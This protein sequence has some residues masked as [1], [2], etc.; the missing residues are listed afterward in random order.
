MG[1][2]PHSSAA[3]RNDTR[4]PCLRKLY[5]FNWSQ[6]GHWRRRNQWYL[7]RSHQ[8]LQPQQGTRHP[9]ASRCERGTFLLK[10]RLR[11]SR[12][13]LRRKWKTNK[14]KTEIR[15]TQKSVKLNWRSIPANREAIYWR[16]VSALKASSVDLDQDLRLW[17]SWRLDSSLLISLTIMKNVPTL[18]MWLLIPIHTHGWSRTQRLSHVGVTFT[19]RT[20]HSATRN[21]R[22]HTKIH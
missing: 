1:V 15:E 5:L 12:M 4:S 19:F 18:T 22:T 2:V 6:T 16:L 10:S 8:S 20:H 14:L 17:L 9:M 3:T 13:G 7:Y 11:I 21:A